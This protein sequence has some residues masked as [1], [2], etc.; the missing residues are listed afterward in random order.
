MAES[1]DSNNALWESSEHS[2]LITSNFAD[3][4]RGGGGQNSSRDGQD[5]EKISGDN[6]SSIS[7][8]GDPVA[9]LRNGTDEYLDDIAYD[10]FLACAVAAEGDIWYRNNRQL[11]ELVAREG[12][13]VKLLKDDQWR[14]LDSLVYQKRD[15]ILKAKTGFGK[16]L[17]FQLAPLL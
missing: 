14:A 8:A 11:T 1:T 2:N 12:F 7:I 16:S 13:G 3:F 5:I 17:I 9:D 15:T 6:N 4:S 10:E